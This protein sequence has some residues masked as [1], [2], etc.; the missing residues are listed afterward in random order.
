MQNNLSYKGRPLATHR[1][2][3]TGKTINATPASRTAIT[4]GLIGGEVPL[5]A[6][7]VRDPYG[8]DEGIG[9]DF[10]QPQT[11]FLHEQKVV[12]VKKFPKLAGSV[13]QWVEVV[14]SGEYVEAMVKLN[15][16]AGTSILGP[17]NGQFALGAV[18]GGTDGAIRTDTPGNLG[19]DLGA[20]AMT[21]CALA[22]ETADTSAASLTT[23][24]G[25][26][27]PRQKVR[28]GLLSGLSN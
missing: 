9:Q 10:T 15:A 4:T 17:V 27:S 5:G 7:L 24:A 14:E 20:I 11:S 26:S 8:P 6:V 22:L 21:A 28:F 25:V 13:G 19:A 23:A 18:A 12:V 3:F 1:V 2:F 16:T